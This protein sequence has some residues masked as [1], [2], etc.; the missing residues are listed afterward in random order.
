MNK[1]AKFGCGYVSNSCSSAK[2]LLDI[3]NNT[4]QSIIVNCIPAINLYYDE[5]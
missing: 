1:T 5:A 3:T 2:H 4:S